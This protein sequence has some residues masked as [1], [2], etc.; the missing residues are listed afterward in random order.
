VVVQCKGLV[1]GEERIVNATLDK[2]HITFSNLFSFK[3]QLGFQRCGTDVATLEAIDYNKDVEM[4]LEHVASKK[5]LRLLM[6]R[7]QEQERHVNITP[8]KRPREYEPDDDSVDDDTLGSDESVD[9]Y[10]D[11]L[12]EEGSGTGIND[13]FPALSTCTYYCFLYS[14]NI[15]CSLQIYEMTI[16]M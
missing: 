10:K 11:W 6:S 13:F 12:K 4:M 16:G 3:D 9:A 5:K 2:A 14:L 1:E 8:L 15:V 7:N